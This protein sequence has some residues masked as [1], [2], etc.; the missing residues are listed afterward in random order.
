MRRLLLT[1]LA[2]VLCV[3]ASTASA[4]A[5]V[6][7]RLSATHRKPAVHK[8]LHGLKA[9]AL[10][11]PASGVQVQQMPAI[12]WGA[13]SGAVE[14]EYQVA[15]DPR[16][17]SIVLGSGIGK[18]TSITHN[19]A[20]A[21]EKPLTDGKYYWRVRGLTAQGRHGA[22]SST[23]AIVKKW[24]QVPQL[25]SPAGGAAVSAPA[26]VVLRWSRVPSATEYIVTVATDPGL[27]HVIVGTATSPQKTWG[28]VFAVPDG[29][30][31]GQTYYWAITPLDTLGHRGAVSATGSFT[32]TWSSATTTSVTPLNAQ[33]GETELNWTPELSWAPVAGAARYEVEVSSAENYPEGSIW[34][35]DYTIGNTSYAPPEA[36]NNNEYY[37]RVRA[38]DPNGIAGQWN[39][40]P[41]FRKA[42]DNATPTIPGLTMSNT[43]GEA[44]S[45]GVETETPIVTWAPVPGAGSYEVQVARYEDEGGYCD[46]SSHTTIDTATLAWTPLG[47]PHRFGPSNWPVPQGAGDE[48]QAGNSYCVQVTARS[49]K[50]H[51]GTYIEGVPTQLGGAGHP[52]FTFSGTTEAP[53]PSVPVTASSAYMLPTSGTTTVRTP[54]FT[55]QPVPGASSYDVVIARD[56]NFTNVVVVA[57][58]E[59]TAYAPRLA[60]EVPFDDET[61]QYY[62]AVVPVN[63][64][65]EI[66][67]TV[68]ENA[69]QAFD[70][71]SVP[72]TP[73]SVREEG[74]GIAFAWT[75]AEGA[76]NYTIE[77]SA[78]PTF[79]A[80]LEAKVT[81]STAYTSSAT[82]PAYGTLWWRVRANDAAA[83]AYQ[84]LNWSA[85][86]QFSRALPLTTP[87]P[88]TPPLGEEIPVLSWQAVP[89]AVGYGIHFE[90]PDGTV[91][92]FT[93]D[94]TAF[95]PTEWDGPGV[96]RYDTRALFPKGLVPTEVATVAGGYFTPSRSFSH[97]LGPPPGAAGTK[98]GNRIVVSWSPEAYANEYT[99][100]ISTSE[101]FS[102]N[103]ETHRTDGTSWAPNVDRSKPANRG[104]VYWRVAAVDNRNNVGP[105][106][107]GRLGPPKPAC[108]KKTVKRHGKKVKVCVAAKHKKKHG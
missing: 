69:P 11:S 27:S 28:T 57:S 81:D 95:T 101:S 54:L 91:K 34:A 31:P 108:V 4:T 15:A 47:T 100:S 79:S 32:R 68:Q 22:W 40:G 73:L 24:T 96:W 75:P 76:V 97:T 30:A 71:S 74:A 90:Q 80:P 7:G 50:D 23:R 17:H 46:W 92:D 93:T 66:A 84:G 82:F 72:P 9:P 62:W 65:N 58:T 2:T 98:S 70:K 107:T 105:Y 51:S 44:V 41:R 18:G 78:D 33:P 43:K 16:F 36:L 3:A 25:L 1:V 26:P 5:A 87:F 103:I 102:S 35:R 48:V 49:D 61:T 13:V 104:T 63:K 45:P 42:F 88:A 52:A 20:A 64:K 99:V 21:L 8:A 56:R 77:V 106:A 29:I 59:V 86:Q 38:I 6:Q 12:S 19:L 67:T 60:T 14:Y 94:S 37:W 55:W 53:G 85:P 83:L 39:E 89:G 10:L